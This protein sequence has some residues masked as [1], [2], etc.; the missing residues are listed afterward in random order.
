ML[1]SGVREKLAA[2]SSLASAWADLTEGG[3]WAGSGS[4]ALA[5]GTAG[6]E[7]CILSPSG[8]KGVPRGS[9]RLHL[10]KQEDEEAS[11][12]CARGVRPTALF[13]LPFTLSLRSWFPQVRVSSTGFPNTHS[14][15]PLRNVLGPHGAGKSQSSDTRGRAG[16]KELRGK[17]YVERRVSPRAQRLATGVKQSASFPRA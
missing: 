10:R 1:A 14:R 3:T 9:V 4:R 6:S 13:H 15:K 7:C 12:H 11:S 16:E 17:I 2:Q 8:N 5:L